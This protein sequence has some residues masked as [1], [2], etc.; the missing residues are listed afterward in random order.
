M[1]VYLIGFMGSGK[2]TAGK[3]LANKLGFKFI[4]LDDF[5]EQETGLSISEYFEKFGEK[6]FRE[7]ESEMLSKVSLFDKVVISTGGGTPCFFNNMDTINKSGV[8]V[9]LKADISLIMSR[10][11]AEKNQRP[12]IK[13]KTDEEMRSYLSDLL[14]G[15]E[16]YYQQAHIVVDAKSLNI[17]DLTDK[18]ILFAKR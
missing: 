9:Y 8:S 18:I 12:L 1:R 6:K 3:K 16:K 13:N 15:R 4:D 11:K 5:I 10:L 14:T 7:L 17:N 2:S